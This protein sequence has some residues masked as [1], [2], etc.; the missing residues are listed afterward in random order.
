MVSLTTFYLNYWAQ[1]NKSWQHKTNI[2]SGFWWPFKRKIRNSMHYE[3]VYH[4]F[5]NKNITNDERNWNWRG[6][7]SISVIVSP[8]AHR[9]E[10]TLINNIIKLLKNYI[11]TKNEERCT[12]TLCNFISFF[13]H[14]K[15][16]CIFLYDFLSCQMNNPPLNGYG[17]LFL[18]LAFR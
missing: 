17:G 15:N 18:L 6:K 7:I 9:T 10:S 11:F 14:E 1:K 3:F 16:C 13:L 4:K 5:D 8:D 2:H 12:Q